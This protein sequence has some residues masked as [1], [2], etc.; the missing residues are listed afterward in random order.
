MHEW[1]DGMLDTH[2]VLLLAEL[3]TELWDYP[4]STT[5]RTVQLSNFP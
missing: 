5:N 1:C 3:A 2:T 4:I